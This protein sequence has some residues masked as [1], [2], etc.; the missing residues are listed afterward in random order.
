MSTSAWPSV[1]AAVQT[2]VTNALPTVQVVRGRDVNRGPGDVIMIGVQ[3]VDPVGNEAAGTVTQGRQT[4]GG[5]REESGA[6][7]GIIVATNTSLDQGT[8]CNQAFTYLAAIENAIRADDT[9]GLTAYEYLHSEFQSG[10]V[11]ESQNT[12]DGARTAVTF[13]VYYT[14]RI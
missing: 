1:I 5:N 11:S 10:S 3:S 8:A 12:T 13:T 4:F 14:A 6:V 9:L 2:T 7:M